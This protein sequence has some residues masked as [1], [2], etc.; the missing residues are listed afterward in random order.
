MRGKRNENPVFFD[1]PLH[2]VRKTTLADVGM[3][4]MWQIPSTQAESNNIDA[5]LNGCG[6][7]QHDT[8]PVIFSNY[9]P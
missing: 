6:T 5:V 7:Q 8:I 9:W 1:G 4:S 2:E 3:P